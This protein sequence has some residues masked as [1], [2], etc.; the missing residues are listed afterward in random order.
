MTLFIKKILSFFLLIAFTVLS[1]SFLFNSYINKKTQFSLSKNVTNII[2]GH[3]HPEVAFNDSLI[4]N[5]QNL[6]QSGES[7]FYTFLKAKQVFKNNPQIENVFI[8]FS[9]IDVTR[10]RDKEIWS[11]K[12]INWRYPNYAAWMRLSEQT[13]LFT[14][15]PKSV[16]KVIPK[17]LKKQWERI[18]EK[19]FNY[20]ST[21]S[22]YLYV[23]ESKLDSLI[24]S[25]YHL[26]NPDPDYFKKSNENL[27]Y[28]NKLIDLCLEYDKN[29]YFV[30]SPIFKNSFYMWNESLFQEI[31]NKQF[32]NIPFLDYVNY[33][34][35]NSYFRDLHH[36]NFM[37]A[38]DFS[39]QFNEW[40]QNKKPKN[41]P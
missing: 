23:N 32:P 5:F 29:V 35:P 34:V 8:E 16:V 15:N 37:G 14:K 12:Y 27:Y 7:Y 11:D 40:L 39:R 13:L 3:S 18:I 10:V 21:T 31:R 26:Q 36:L 24:Q 25:N 17:T 30:R 6:A 4:S 2:F 1:V 22:G 33:Q 9:N 38:A 28:L 41:N 20:V 19:Q